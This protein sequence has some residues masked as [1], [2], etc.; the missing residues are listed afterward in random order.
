[1]IT[2]FVALWK[3]APLANNDAFLIVSGKWALPRLLASIE[4]SGLF[5]SLL[6]K[7]ASSHL[8]NCR[9]RRTASPQWGRSSRGRGFR[10]CFYSTGCRKLP[11]S[12]I[13]HIRSTLC[14][15]LSYQV[16]TFH[17]QNSCWDKSWSWKDDLSVR[18][19]LLETAEEFLR[20]KRSWKNMTNCLL[21]CS[22]VQGSTS[23][24]WFDCVSEHLKLNQ[25]TYE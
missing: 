18:V 22:S 20:E 5:P 10:S 1:M 4:T 23:K 9:C 25:G 13:C 16:R 11:L 3:C 15:Q 6:V 21:L 14:W 17:D 24:I 12:N 2:G 8:A 19:I 7:T